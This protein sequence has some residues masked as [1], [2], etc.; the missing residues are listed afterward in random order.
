M[1]ATTTVEGVQEVSSQEED[2]SAQS[3]RREAVGD[4]ELLCPSA[5]P[6]EGA[7]LLSIAGPDGNA[8]YLRGRIPVTAEFLTEANKTH[9]V[10]QRFRFASP[11]RRDDCAQWSSNKCTVPEKLTQLVPSASDTDLPRCSIRASCRWYSQSGFAACRICPLVVRTKE[12]SEDRALG[13]SD[14]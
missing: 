6:E 13:G 3:G 2:M 10:E 8:G 1:I 11:C 14:D 4:H 7:L 12:G 5:P 9:S